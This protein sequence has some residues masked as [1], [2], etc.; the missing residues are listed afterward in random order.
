MSEE[1]QNTL[2]EVLNSTQIEGSI[3][4]NINNMLPP[5]NSSYKNK[6]DIENIRT[7][8]PERIIV[9]YTIRN[10][11]VLSNGNSENME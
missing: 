6:L 9:E 7:K 3:G 2:A 10:K 5:E 4:N 8:R 11:E 1:V